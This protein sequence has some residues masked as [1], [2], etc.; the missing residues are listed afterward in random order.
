M[1]NNVNAVKAANT[2]D[3]IKPEKIIETIWDHLKD[4][5]KCKEITDEH[6]AIFRSWPA[7]SMLL[8]KI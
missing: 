1:A 6:V 8:E 4:S 5:K 7:I 3:S 2:L